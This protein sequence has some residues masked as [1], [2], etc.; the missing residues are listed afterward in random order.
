MAKQLLTARQLAV[1]L[2]IGESSIYPILKYDKG[3][4][5]HIVGKR[6]KYDYD[7]IVAYFDE[8]ELNNENK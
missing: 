5:Y 2:G 6:K 1:L 7:E 8:K 4:P 3:I